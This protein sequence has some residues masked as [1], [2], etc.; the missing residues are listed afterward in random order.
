MINNIKKVVII[1]GG[2]AGMMAAIRASQLVKNVIL[3][4]K[5]TALGEKLLLTGNG[6]CNLTNTEPLESFL[7]G[8][9]GNGNFL[10]DACKVFFNND[11]IQFFESRKLP[12]ITE[13][14]GKI[15]PKTNS[16]SSV[17]DALE[18]ELGNNNVKII[19]NTEL[20]D[21]LVQNKKVKAVYFRNGSQL[22]VD[23]LIISTGGITYRS[24]GSDGEGMKIVERLGHTIV[25]LRP[26]LVPLLTDKKYPAALNGLSLK[27][28]RVVFTFD[29]KKITSNIG[30]LLF[31]RNGISGP[32]ILSI[33]GQIV[34]LLQKD[35]TISAFIDLIP[36]QSIKEVE[37]TLMNEL[38][39]NYKKSVST[40]LKKRYP[41]RLIDLAMNDLGID[42]KVTVSQLKASDRKKIVSF[43][44]GIP[45]KIIGFESLEKAMITMGGISLKEIDP[46]TMSSKVIDGLFFAGEMID[47][48]GDTGGYN[49]QEAFSTGYLAG[50]SVARYVID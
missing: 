25:S 24:T 14:D 11:L 48:D 23:C 18:N 8:Y 30:D 22:K 13:R 41:Y 38:K 32:L 40:V 16:A 5:N 46:R 3:V 31:T 20:T 28:V 26:G 21:I 6:R 45:L 10:R 17:R 34:N 37:T 50:E 9:A 42:P 44:K 2:P 49:L 12:L 1:G 47:I 19:F 4:E 39:N 36:Q 35:I 33:S 15:F 27:Q 7:K 29:T 43:L